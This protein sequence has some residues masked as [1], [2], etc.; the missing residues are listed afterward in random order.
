MSRPVTIFKKVGPAMVVD[1]K[2]KFLEFGINSYRNAAHIIQC[3]TAIVERPDGSVVNIPLEFIRFN[4]VSPSAELKP[5]EVH[6]F[7]AKERALH[8]AVVNGEASYPEE[9]PGI[10]S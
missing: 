6:P 4:D 7:T 10:H 1:S 5:A 8:S 9:D 3:T 2:G